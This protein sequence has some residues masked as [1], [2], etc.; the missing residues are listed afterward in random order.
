MERVILLNSDY[1]YLN[2]IDWRKAVCFVFKKK[3]EVVSATSRKV[4]NP[5]RTFEMFVPKVLRLIQL[6]RTV[7]KRKAVFSARN[8]FARDNHT[9]QYCGK[10]KT[11]LTIDHIVPKSRGGKT[12]FENCVAACKE[13]NGRKADRTLAEAGM[14]IRISPYHPMLIELTFK[15]M[16]K[17]GLDKVMQELAGG[18]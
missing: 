18:V 2:I 12:G 3:V 16:R 4:S 10:R 9:C 5:D 13:C 7:Y 8:L 1:S 6:V 15:H 11:N 14:R 17:L